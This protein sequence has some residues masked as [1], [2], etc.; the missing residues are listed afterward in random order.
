MLTN[1]ILVLVYNIQGIIKFL[2]IFVENKHQDVACFLTK[3]VDLHSILFVVTLL[4]FLYIF[5][6][7]I[8]FS[9]FS[10]LGLNLSLFLCVI[11]I[12][13]ISNLLID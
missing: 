9:I 8:I 10:R 5:Y 3:M 13:G 11:L 1:I 4:D 6:R 2:I 7:S 12:E